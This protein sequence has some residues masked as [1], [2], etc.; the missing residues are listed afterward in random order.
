MKLSAPKLGKSHANRDELV[1]L[2]VVALKVFLSLARAFR[3]KEAARKASCLL[4]PE[5]QVP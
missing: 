3:I 4:G 1:T 5:A 2:R